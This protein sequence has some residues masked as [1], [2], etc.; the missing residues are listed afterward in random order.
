MEA[1]DVL[2]TIEQSGYSRADIVRFTG[3]SPAALSLI[4]NGERSGK[5]S[6]PKLRSMMESIQAAHSPTLKAPTIVDSVPTSPPPIENTSL[7]PIQSSEMIPSSLAQQM[8][9]ELTSQRLRIQNLEEQ[10]RQQNQARLNNLPSRSVQSKPQ[11]YYGPS[12]YLQSPQTHYRE[13]QQWRAQEYHHLKHS[14]GQVSTHPQAETLGT[15][16]GRFIRDLLKSATS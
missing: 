7:T 8:M 5:T 10:V 4:A 12:P 16:L 2:N 6:L 1:V 15:L 9:R 13:L 14:R 3:I 11:Q